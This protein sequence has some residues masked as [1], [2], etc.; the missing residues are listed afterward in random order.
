MSQDRRSN[1]TRPRYRQDR[2]GDTVIEKAKNI[3]SN[4]HEK[5]LEADMGFEV[6]SQ[7]E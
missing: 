6:Q 5:D 7:E 2:I 4:I 3:T 1:E